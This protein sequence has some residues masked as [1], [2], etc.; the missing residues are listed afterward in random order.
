[1]N[2]NVL[3]VLA[4]GA[5]VAVLVAV[6][7]SAVLGGGKKKNVQ[8]VQ[9]VQQVDVLVAKADIKVGAKLNEENLDWKSWPQ[10]G[11]FP[12][13]IIRKDKQKKT[14]AIDGRMKY[15]VAQGM[16]IIKD[17]VIEGDASFIEASLKPGMRA[18]ALNVKPSSIAGGFIGAGSMVD[19]L[20]TYNV[21]IKPI[22]TDKEEKRAQ[23]LIIDEIIDRFATE[24]IM[25]NVKV[26]AVDQSP[27]PDPEKAKLGKTVTVEVTPKQAELLFVAQSSGQLSLA[28]RGIG[29]NQVLK[30]EE[31]VTTDEKLLGAF[32][33]VMSELKSKSGVGTATNAV[34]VYDGGNQK[35][36]LVK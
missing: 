32:D 26:L 15:P 4:G 1:M 7:V 28:L 20:I 18:I 13:T 16:P 17:H 9:Q 29:D 21:K 30:K 35:S 27:V 10:N 11:T 23:E 14:E 2:K 34:R 8:T 36:Y 25:Q 24:T 5:L 19:V 22:A 6:L 12:G 31:E 3:I 33:E